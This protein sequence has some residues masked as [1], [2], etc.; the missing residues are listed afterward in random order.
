MAQT[1]R[2]SA[3]ETGTGMGD[4]ARGDRVESRGTGQ[5]DIVRGQGGIVGTKG[6]VASWGTGQGGFMRGHR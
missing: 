1:P 4:I 2:G 5:G 3:G 6:Q